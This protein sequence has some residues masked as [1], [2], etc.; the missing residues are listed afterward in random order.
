MLCK[1]YYCVVFFV[2]LKFN[3]LKIKSNIKTVVVGPFCVYIEY[4]IIMR[5]QMNV[6]IYWIVYVYNDRSCR[7]H[8][9]FYTP[10]YLCVYLCAYYNKLVSVGTR[11]IRLYE[12]NNVIIDNVYTRGH[13]GYISYFNF[14]DIQL[15][16]QYSIY[17]Y[18]RTLVLLKINYEKWIP[19]ARQRIIHL[20]YRIINN[21]LCKVSD[22]DSL[23]LP[24]TILK[25]LSSPEAFGY[26]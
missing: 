6:P 25:A 16:S 7:I 17:R 5:L 13:H 24:K 3:S 9:L 2:N 12:Y 10:V 15:F 21:I 8:I 11:Q 18:S 26:R 14:H 20:I 19:L 4:D 1:C 23:W 22:H